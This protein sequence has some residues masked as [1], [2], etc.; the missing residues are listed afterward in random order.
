M[1]IPETTVRQSVNTLRAGTIY[2]YF[3]VGL[4]LA[5]VGCP[6]NAIAPPPIALE[7]CSKTETDWPVF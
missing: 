7:S 6:N 4:K 5:V 1:K 3:E 2:S